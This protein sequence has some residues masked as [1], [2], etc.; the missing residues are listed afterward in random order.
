MKCTRRR[1]RPAPSDL[2]NWKLKKG[3]SSL[4]RDGEEGQG[5]PSTRPYDHENPNTP[6][7]CSVNDRHLQSGHSQH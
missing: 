5:I 2:K 6:C 4:R 1:N 3:R 7:L